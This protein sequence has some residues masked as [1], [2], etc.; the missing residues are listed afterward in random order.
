VA[1]SEVSAARYID[2]N[3]G[4]VRTL[5]GTGLFAFGDRDG[6]F[7]SALFQHGL[8]IDVSGSKV[9]FADTYNDRIKEIDLEKKTVKNILV[10]V[11]RD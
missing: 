4:K 5:V 11:S 10:L 3:E 9:Y 6:D 8:G 7:D 2:L 1:D